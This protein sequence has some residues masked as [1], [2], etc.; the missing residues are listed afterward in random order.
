MLQRGARDLHNSGEDTSSNASRT[1]KN[2]KNRYECGTSSQNVMFL[3]RHCA[4]YRW[5]L[6]SYVSDAND[7]DYYCSS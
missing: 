6:K 3:G 5:L 7:R 2:T 4:V 1:G